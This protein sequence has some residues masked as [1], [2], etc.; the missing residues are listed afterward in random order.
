M[1]TYSIGHIDT[2]LDVI[3]SLNLHTI[4]IPNFWSM[5]YDGTLEYD[6]YTNV[7]LYNCRQLETMSIYRHA[8]KN[9]HLS[10]FNKT[11]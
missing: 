10:L 3:N 2:P 11:N 6:L 1:C 8:K 7:H 9:C 5:R 4:P